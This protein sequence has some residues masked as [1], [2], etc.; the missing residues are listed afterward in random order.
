MGNEQIAEKLT[1][2]QASK[3]TI[4]VMGGSQG[5]AKINEVIKENIDA[6]NE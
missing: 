4:I 2:F 1:G 3:E 5:S 6:I